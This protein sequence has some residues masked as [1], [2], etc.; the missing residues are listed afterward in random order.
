MRCQPST[1]TNV[2]RH[3][4]HAQGHQDGRNEEIDDE[5]RQEQQETHLK[6]GLQLADDESRD[7]DAHRQI[8]DRGRSK[9]AQFKEIFQIAGPRLLQHELLQR[10]RGLFQRRGGGDPAVEIRHERLFVHAVENRTHDEKGQEQRE[11]D[12]DL[13]RRRAGHTEGGAHETEHDH[14][15]GEA[16][17]EQHDRRRE[18]QQRHDH[19]DLH[20][21]AHLGGTLRSL[22][23][24]GQAQRIGRFGRRRGGRDRRR[25]R[26]GV[27]LRRRRTDRHRGRQH[28]KKDT[29]EPLHGVFGRSSSSDVSRLIRPGHTP[30]RNFFSP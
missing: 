9:A 28:G 7:D 15:P 4:H 6:R 17:H 2:G 18:R 11:P 16:R 8:L 14:D 21:D 10:L 12:D 1:R 22:Q 30:S 25:C 27:R 13:V 20:G 29:P 23:A 3:H 24:D 5:E 19:H 26:Q